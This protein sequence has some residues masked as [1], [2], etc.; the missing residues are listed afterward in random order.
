MQ[1]RDGVIGVKG[2]SVANGVVRR[3]FA[4]QHAIFVFHFFN[5]KAVGS[6]GV[7]VYILRAMVSRGVQCSLLPSSVKPEKKTQPDGGS[8]SRSPYP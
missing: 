2:Y 8:G 3:C 4:A 5:L 1:G 7:G 6:S